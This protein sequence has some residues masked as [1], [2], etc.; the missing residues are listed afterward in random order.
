[1]QSVK[2]KISVFLLNAIVLLIDVS[3]Y[4]YLIK[5]TSKQ[6]HL[7][8]CYS[9]NDKC[10]ID[11]KRND[12]LKENDIKIRMCYYFDNI[13]KIEDFNL[14]TR[15]LVLIGSEKYNFIYNRIRYLKE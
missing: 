8:P 9:P 1:M 12:E 6:K 13:I 15:Y 2:Q 5:Y 11:M 4:C 3:I 14:E 10:I 7:L